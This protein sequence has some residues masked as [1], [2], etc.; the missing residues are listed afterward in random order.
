MIKTESE[1][2]VRQGRTV[3]TWCPVCQARVEVFLLGD[4]GFA[5][6][7]LRGMTAGALHVWTP[8]EGQTQICLPSLLACGQSNEVTR[9][10]IPD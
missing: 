1:L 10:G 7:M 8:A 9:I 2:I 5:S 4:K 3:V 6:Q